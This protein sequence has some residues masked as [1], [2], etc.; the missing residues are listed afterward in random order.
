MNL[1]SGGASSSNI[2]TATTTLVRTGAGILERVICNKAV[3]SGTI[4]IYDGLSAS[5]TKLATI[6][7]PATLLQNQY[8]L[9]YGVR[10]GTG[11]TIVTGQADDLTI[12]YT[13]T[14]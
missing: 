4:T 1:D 5:G 13:P 14:L 11:L 2:T 6:T 3:L 10:F 9:N 8:E 7:H 12:V